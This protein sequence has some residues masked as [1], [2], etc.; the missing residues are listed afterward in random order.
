MA[1]EP[2]ALDVTV[3]RRNQVMLPVSMCEECGIGKGDKVRRYWGKN[4]QCVVIVPVDV[5]LGDNAM[6]RIRI[7]TT[8]P[9]DTRG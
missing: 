1:L 7:L 3:S 6:S 2:K 4:Y 5:K 9:L 8:E